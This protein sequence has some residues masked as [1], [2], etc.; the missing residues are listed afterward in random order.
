MR[1]ERVNRFAT[2]D[3]MRGAAAVLV[4]VFHFQQRENLVPIHGYLAVDLFFVLS[5]FV[6]ARAYVPRLAGSMSCRSFAVT[7]V[8]R[9]YPLYFVGLMLGLLSEPFRG[10]LHDPDATK[11]TAVAGSFLFNGAML[12]SP[13][14]GTLFPLNGAAWSLFFE[15]AVNLLF[16]AALWRMTTR[17]LLAIMAASAV[18][19]LANVASPY[20]MNL[21]WSW[22]QLEAG[23]A[24]TLFSFVAGML[25]GRRLG[26]GARR[27]SGWAL[28]P[29]AALIAPLLIVPP[30]GWASAWDIESILFLFPLLVGCA[31]CVEPPT[32]LAPAYCRA[33]ALSYPLYV[34]HW[35]LAAILKPALSQLPPGIGLAIFLASAL[36][37]TEIAA[38]YLAPP[39]DRALRRI[40]RRERD[41]TTTTP[42]EP[43]TLPA[44]RA[45]GPR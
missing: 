34:V 28:V 19:L 8:I 9:L 1:I 26:L 38:R 23:T 30:G 43:R 14:D 39:I 22:S 25:I 42:A 21:G 36:L 45:R 13:F 41:P 29:V 2:L 12:P 32:W 10:A 5:G 37:L 44:P 15:L 7:R 27:E 20:G 16:A 24:R 11:A 35:P 17:W 18:I 33:G 31:V 4:A 3:G 40:W 6:I